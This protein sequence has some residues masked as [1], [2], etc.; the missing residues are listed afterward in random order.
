MAPKG[1]PRTK[2]KAVA[3]PATDELA[4]GTRP[5]KQEQLPVHLAVL[6]FVADEPDPRATDPEQLEKLRQ[7]QEISAMDPAPPIAKENRQ[8]YVWVARDQ[9]RALEIILGQKSPMYTTDPERMLMY[10][11]NK[12][13]QCDCCGVPSFKLY[14]FR[15]Y[16]KLQ[17]SDTWFDSGSAEL[18]EEVEL[19]SDSDDEAEHYFEAYEGQPVSDLSCF[20]QELQVNWLPLK[21]PL[22]ITSSAG[23]S[24]ALALRQILPSSAKSM[25]VQIL[26]GDS[27]TTRVLRNLGCAQGN[28]FKESR[29]LINILLLQQE[30]KSSCYSKPAACVSRPVPEDFS[31]FDQVKRQTCGLL[32]EHLFHGTFEAIPLLKYTFDVQTSQRLQGI[33]QDPIF[34]VLFSTNR[35]NTQEHLRKNRPPIALLEVTDWGKVVKHQQRLRD[36]FGKKIEDMGEYLFECRAMTLPGPL[37]G[38]VLHIFLVLEDVMKKD[39]LRQTVRLAQHL[40]SKLPSR[41]VQDCLLQEEEAQQLLLDLR[42][43]WKQARV[44]LAEGDYT[45]KLSE[46]DKKAGGVGNNFWLIWG[47]KEHH[48]KLLNQAFEAL[49]KPAGAI[50]AGDR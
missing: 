40:C 20:T 46:K 5:R 13:V 11:F 1:R 32:K 10:T 35:L 33:E 49:R 16:K 6:G 12:R 41:S 37:T 38:S 45:K 30:A 22:S 48:Q 47:G 25:K 43:T 4:G 23:V 36:F 31:D 44:Q 3:A 29:A 24:A 28:C 7:S 2:P 9:D 39:K 42:K 26:C 19:E 8:K 15:C 50:Q 17:Q 34:T 21:L 27:A 14:E 18:R